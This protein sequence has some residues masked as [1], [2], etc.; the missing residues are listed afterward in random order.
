MRFKKKVLLGALVGV[1][2]LGATVIIFRDVVL[3]TVM[4]ALIAPS[5]EFDAASVSSSPDYSNSNHWAAL[6]DR[7]DR[8]DRIPSGDFLDGQD[9]AEVDVFFVHPTTYVSAESWNQS[10]DDMV[11]NERTDEFVMEGQASVFNG[12]CRVYAPRYRQATLYSF[13]D[14]EG[15]GEEA[16]ALAYE[17]VATAFNYYLDYFNEGRPFILAGHSQ[18]SHHL[19]GLLANEIVGT[20]LVERLV[21]AYPVGFPIDGS[22]GLPVCETPTQTGCQATWNAVG[23]NV[24]SF[25][26]LSE[27]ICVNP[28]TWR[29]D[30]LSASHELNIGAVNFGE[31]DVPETAVADGA[32]RAGRLW[33]SDIRSSHYGWRPLGRDNYHVYDYALFY[34]NLRENVETRANA[35]LRQSDQEDT[36]PE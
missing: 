6:P 34:L 10:L 2:V 17:D 27:S 36:Q 1:V 8:A 11:T 14:A 13:F 9:L 3:F 19:D 18:G 30:R 23:P 25:L 31:S 21:A 5:H 15:T 12:C 22:N 4:G 35:F 24:G 20:T 7:N 32:C 16:L 26:A 28:L 29:A 33:V